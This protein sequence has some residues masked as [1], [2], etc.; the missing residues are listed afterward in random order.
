MPCPVAATLGCATKVFRS[1]MNF[2]WW[3]FLTRRELLA[4]FRA[5]RRS[6]VRDGVFF[7]DMAAI[8]KDDLAQRLGAWGG[9]D[10]AAEAVA[11]Q[12]RGIGFEILLGQEP[13]LHGA[14]VLLMV[15]VPSRVAVDQYWKMKRQI[16]EA[17]GRINGEYGR[18]DWTPVIYQFRY[19]PFP[20][21]AALYALGDV[22]L[23]TP[24]RDGMNLVAKEFVSARNDDRGV[25]GITY[26]F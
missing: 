8:G 15:V 9:V 14:V 5:V 17:V 26:R 11:R 13:A 25:L 16:E 12:R 20:P 18:A 23:V 3:V 1:A 6:L 21:L 7:L 22:A 24:L 2:S 19:L 10:A 4:Y